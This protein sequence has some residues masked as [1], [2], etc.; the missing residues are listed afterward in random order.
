ME[1]AHRP[2]DVLEMSEF[3]DKIS[4]EFHAYSEAMEKVEDSLTTSEKRRNRN[5]QLASRHL[6]T[7]SAYI[8]EAM[9]RLAKYWSCNET[10]SVRS[11]RMYLLLDECIKRNAIRDI[12][13]TGFW[14]N[15]IYRQHG[16]ARTFCFMR[17]FSAFI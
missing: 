5:Y 15:H 16:F 12:W 9:M 2:L 1:Y 3:A 8:E 4:N 6:R 13:G 17:Y 7:Y 11:R 14:M 10:D